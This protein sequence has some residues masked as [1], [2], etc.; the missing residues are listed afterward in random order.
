MFVDSDTDR[1]SHDGFGDISF[2]FIGVGICEKD[3]DHKK[4]QRCDKVFGVWFTDRHHCRHCGR[5]L[6]GKCCPKNKYTI[7][8]NP[9]LFA[10]SMKIRWKVI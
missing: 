8:I 10:H 4:C 1:G 3:E 7:K 9:N 2:D 6:C 5:V